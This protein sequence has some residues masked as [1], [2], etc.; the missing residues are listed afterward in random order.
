MYLWSSRSL[1]CDRAI[2]LRFASRLCQGPRPPV[3]EISGQI[4]C[5]TNL[6]ASPTHDFP[7]RPCCLLVVADHEEGRCI[8]S[9]RKIQTEN[10]CE[11]C[12]CMSVCVSECECAWLSVRIL[13]PDGTEPLGR[14]VSL[15]Y[16]SMVRESELRT[17]WAAY[18]RQSLNPLGRV[19]FRSPAYE[20]TQRRSTPPSKLNAVSK[21]SA[22]SNL[23]AA[24]KL[25]AVSKV[26]AASKR[27]R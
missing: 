14:S 2:P 11:V 24:S 1:S 8:P 7:H 18:L 6:S 19:L 15:A 23:S 20:R 13:P 17:P 4:F 21:E 12:V 26:S 25:G 16:L 5:V 9:T 10:V 22:V 3:P 27:K